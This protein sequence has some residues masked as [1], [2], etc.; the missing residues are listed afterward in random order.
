MRATISLV[1]HERLYKARGFEIDYK[2]ISS[3]FII[4]MIHQLIKR[5]NLYIHP[6]QGIGCGCNKLF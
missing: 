6:F 5:S 1:Y 4:E 2:Y 3:I